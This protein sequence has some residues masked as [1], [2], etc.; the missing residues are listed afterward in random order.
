MGD[1][2]L[3]QA[4]DARQPPV[5][6]RGQDRQA[7]VIA[8]GKVD[9]DIAG[10]ALE[11]VLVVEDPVGRRRGLLF[12]LAGSGKIGGDLPYPQARPPEP[13][14]QFDGTIRPRVDQLF[15]GMAPGMLLDLGRGQVYRPVPLPDSP[16]APGMDDEQGRMNFA[17]FPQQRHRTLQGING[18][19]EDEDGLAG[20]QP[21]AV[22]VDDPGLDAMPGAPQ[23]DQRRHGPHGGTGQDQ[24]QRNGKT[25]VRQGPQPEPGQKRHR[26]HPPGQA[27]N[28]ANPEGKSAAE[29]VGD[30]N[31]AGQALMHQGGTAVS[32]P[33]QFP[34]GFATFLLLC[35][36]PDKNG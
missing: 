33:Y 6:G 28:H 23:P 29:G 9:Q 4:V 17:A 19:L 5:V 36:I 15:T 20:H 3:G 35:E 34:E 24:G 16:L 26:R 11:D 21:A 31:I 13:L 30:M 1:K 10:V 22:I 25:P 12:Q 32:L 7:Q 14:Q 8:A 2:I 18:R 27:G